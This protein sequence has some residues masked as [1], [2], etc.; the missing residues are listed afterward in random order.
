M[1][2]AIE[3]KAVKSPVKSTPTPRRKGKKA[4][5]KH[6]N[7]GQRGCTQC[8]VSLKRITASSTSTRAADL[9]AVNVAISASNPKPETS[10]KAAKL[11]EL[12]AKAAK[13]VEL[14]AKAAKAKPVADLTAPTKQPL[15]KALV[16]RSFKFAAAELVKDATA[17]GYTHEDGRAALLT[18][19]PDGV[20]AWMVQ[21]PEGGGQT[22]GQ[23]ENLLR[24][25]LDVSST[26]RKAQMGR[27]EP[28]KVADKPVE[29]ILAD[30]PVPVVETK[31]S[32]VLPD[33]PPNH[34]CRAVEMLNKLTA[35]RYDVETLRGDK[36]YGNRM[37]LMRVLF[38]KLP[39][40]VKAAET[41]V[42]LLE[43]AFHT[44]IGADGKSLGGQRT[45]FAER[46]KGL[47]KDYRHA[48]AVAKK[49]QEALDAKLRHAAPKRFVPGTI[50]P[51]VKK[52]TRVQEAAEKELLRQELTL[53]LAVTPEPIAAP[54][55]DAPIYTIVAD[56]VR[57]LEDPG[58]GIVMLQIEKSNSQGALC[59]YNNGS[60]VAVGVVATERLATLRPVPGADVLKAANQLLNPV[61]PTVAV[62]PVA[63]RHL[64]AVLYCKD[65]IDM[66]IVKTSKFAVPVKS[67]PAKKA[68][69]PEAKKVAQKD[70]GVT[71]IK[72][73]EKEDLPA[74]K[75]TPAPAKKATPAPAKK[76]TPAPAKKA[77]PAPAKKA[78]PAPAKKATPAPAKKA[79]PAPAKKAA[80]GA[81]GGKRVRTLEGHKIV[82]LSR[83]H[84]AR[85]GSRAQVQTDILLKAKTT[86]AALTSGVERRTVYNAVS[87]G[88]IELA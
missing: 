85:P 73:S 69:E 65:L 51:G 49:V 66:D 56:D 21:W 29:L 62:T 54:K 9:K 2:K 82:V 20:W 86:D 6:E 13:L 42:N 63:A 1:P 74:K 8:G 38:N 44:A 32:Q 53:K 7:C 81:V 55:P 50:L 84:G 68:T 24:K 41:G 14:S 4:P 23:D 67:T 57:L 78:T 43:T 61:V 75:A 17:Y 34:V 77:T 80:E 60:R 47:V 46:C 15:H 87:A 27:G 76:A 70:L 3:S 40:E 19:T 26:R 16:A 36:H 45:D 5:C 22:G 37:A 39:G 83:E 18:A 25:A 48:Q 79:T 11:V 35:G 31:T 59:V 64:T 52:Q 58:N 30:P 33:G 10:A 71:V 12:S 28:L 72:A 88:L